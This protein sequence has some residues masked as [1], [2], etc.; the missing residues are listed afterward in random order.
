MNK[1]HQIVA[2]IGFYC[3]FGKNASHH[4]QNTDTEFLR[5]RQAK[6]GYAGLLDLDSRHFPLLIW[7]KSFS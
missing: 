6:L 7:S 1:Y 5:F 2:V 4:K 3:I